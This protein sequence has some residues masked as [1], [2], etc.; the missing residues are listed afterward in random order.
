MHLRIDNMNKELLP[1]QKKSVKV[2]K[3]AFS[4]TPA[5]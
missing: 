4:I 2:L 5:G 1:D 3:T